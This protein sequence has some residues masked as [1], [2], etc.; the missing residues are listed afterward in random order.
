M[1]PSTYETVSAMIAPALFL[2]A[3]AS[4]I[5][6]TTNRMGRIIDRIRKLIELGNQIAQGVAALDFPEARLTHI[7]TLLQNLQGRNRRI[8]VTVSELYL[9]FGAFVGT[10]LSIAIDSATGRHLDGLPTFF[11]V[12]GVVLLLLASM[13]LVAE[14]RIATRTNHLE[15]EFY[16]ELCKLRREQAQTK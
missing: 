13:N 9:A 11:A 16:H 2:T 3:T 12:A 1:N 6:S 7:E 15:V 4:L 5:V 8:L 14:V 10:S